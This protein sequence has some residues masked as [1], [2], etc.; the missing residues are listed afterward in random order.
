M[1]LLPLWYVV[2][3]AVGR[4]EGTWGV[5]VG[6]L[7]LSILLR[8]QER[9]EPAVVLLAV[10]LVAVLWG[11]LRGRAGQPA[12]VLQVAGLVAWSALVLAGLLLDPATG[13]YV[14]A[15]GWFAHGL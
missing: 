11:A 2:I 10:A 5:M 1:L 4:R 6:S 12:F 9:I 13:R 14:I 3:A 8:F 7:A 15:A